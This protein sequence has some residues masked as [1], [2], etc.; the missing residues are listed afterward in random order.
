MRALRVSPCY[1]RSVWGA[2][3]VAK[4]VSIMETLRIILEG[5]GILSMVAALACTVLAF[6]FS[7]LRSLGSGA[8]RGPRPAAIAIVGALGCLGILLFW[9]GRSL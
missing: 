1:K 3:E 2:D 4:V 7:G 9:A 8:G 6:V 5:L